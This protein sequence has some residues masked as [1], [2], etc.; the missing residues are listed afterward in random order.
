VSERYA[1]EPSEHSRN[2]IG[3]Y[4]QNQRK[5]MDDYKMIDKGFRKTTILNHG[6]LVDI[7]YY[8]TS[9][10]PGARARDAVTG[11]RFDIRVGSNEEHN[12]FKVGCAIGVP[13]NDFTLLFYESPDAYEKHML[14][15]ISQEHKESWRNKRA[16]AMKLRDEKR[17]ERPGVIT[18]R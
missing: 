1:Y 7:E 8:L 18:V 15:P 6:K 16:I 3:T 14:H 10:T 4:R 5:N 13:D 11:A 17:V 9:N 12:L 2:T